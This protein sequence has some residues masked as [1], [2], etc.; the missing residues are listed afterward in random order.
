M[1]QII[2]WVALI[3][4][5]GIMIYALK[6]PPTKDWIIVFF[7]KGFISLISNSFF[8]AYGLLSYPIRFFPNVFPTTIVFDMVG[9]PMLCVLY[10]QTTYKSSIKGILVQGILYSAGATLFE[11]WAEQ[12]S[13]LITFNSWE[14]YHSFLFFAVTFL[15][16]RAILALI[17]KYAKENA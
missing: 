9:Y 14:W 17:R 1:A 5:I 3:L 12:N 8:V 4:S 13:E 15:G 16:V 10:N 7:V 2:N 6:K 11:V